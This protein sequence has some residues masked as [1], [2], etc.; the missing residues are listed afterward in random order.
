M[1]LSSELPWNIFHKQTLTKSLD[2]RVKK[3]KKKYRTSCPD[4]MVQTRIYCSSLLS[5]TINPGNSINGNQRKTER[6]KEEGRLH[7]DPQRKEKYR[8]RESC[9]SPP[10]STSDPCQA[11]SNPKTRTE[12]YS[13]RFIPPLDRIGILTER[14]GNCEFYISKNF[15]NEVETKTFSNEKKLRNVSLADLPLKYSCKFFKQKGND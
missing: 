6:Q 11:S 3:K 13:G 9:D 7:R 4:K 2:R 1:Q 10:N 14:N 12:S 5:T 15:M 8:G